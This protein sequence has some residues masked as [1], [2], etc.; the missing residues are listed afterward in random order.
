[1]QYDAFN[2]HPHECHPSMPTQ[3]PTDEISPLFRLAQDERSPLLHLPPA[4]QSRYLQCSDLCLMYCRE[5]RRHS[6]KGQR[7]AALGSQNVDLLIR[8]P[9][10]DILHSTTSIHGCSRSPGLSDQRACYT[11]YYVVRCYPTYPGVQAT[12]YPNRSKPTVMPWHYRG[13]PLLLQR[14]SE[15]DY[16]EVMRALAQHPRERRREAERQ[17]GRQG[18]G[19]REI[20]ACYCYS[21][22]SV[23]VLNSDGDVALGHA[24]ARQNYA[25]RYGAPTSN[26]TPQTKTAQV[27]SIR[28]T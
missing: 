28:S 2:C 25:V 23:K 24:C 9:F 3:L 17:R 7:W 4:A 5:Q 18:L 1:M 12:L 21:D 19:E 6:P 13:I 22:R 26:T 11:V 10:Q 27:G 15:D 14:R 8:T 16:L 20:S